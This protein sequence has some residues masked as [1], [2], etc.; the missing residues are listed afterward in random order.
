MGAL[1][2]D[3][4]ALPDSPSATLKRDVVESEL[5]HDSEVAAAVNA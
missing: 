1:L 5:Y 4:G 3:I 2:R